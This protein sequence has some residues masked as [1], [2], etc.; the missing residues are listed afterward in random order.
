VAAGRDGVLAFSITDASA[1]HLEG[2]FDTSG[3]ATDLAVDGTTVYAST[4]KSRHWVLQGD[5][6]ASDCR[7]ESS[8]APSQDVTACV[9]TAVLLDGSAY[10]ATSVPANAVTFQWYEDGVPIPGAT[11]PT[12]TVP[13]THPEAPSPS[14]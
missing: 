11:D 12:Y 7:I 1:P 8:I 9:G 10:Q 2:F 6:L 3:V 4:G 5:M 13:A 14:G